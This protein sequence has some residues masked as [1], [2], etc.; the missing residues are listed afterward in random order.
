MDR[1]FTVTPPVPVGSL[2]FEDNFNGLTLDTTKW[3]AKSFSDHGS[4][5]FWDG[6]NR[7][8]LDGNGNLVITASLVSGTWR[9]AWIAAKQQ[10]LGP[11]YIQ[12]MAKVPSGYGTW[13]APVWESG[14]GAPQLEIDVCEQLGRQPNAYHATLHNWYAPGQNHASGKTISSSI[15]LASAFHVYGADVHTDHV[16]FYLDGVKKATVL[17][18]AISLTDLTA[19]PVE[20][21]VNLHM[22]GSWAGT[23]TIKGPVAML[24]DYISVY[25]RV[26]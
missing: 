8:K 3:A 18:S 23:P 6:L 9:S 12:A 19:W 10:Y 5:T 25:E 7:V 26:K 16:D 15:P 22:G 2:L 1:S 17:A 24:V 4:S 11:R 21:N 14:H 20:M 13:S